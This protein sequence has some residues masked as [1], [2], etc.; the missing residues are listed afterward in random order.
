MVVVWNTYAFCAVASD[1]RDFRHFPWHWLVF[2]PKRP[3]DF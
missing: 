3:D 2:G 1:T